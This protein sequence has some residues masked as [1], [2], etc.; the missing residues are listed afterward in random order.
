MPKRS[1]SSLDQDRL[2]RL[3][4]AQDGVVSRSQLVELGASRADVRRLVARREL[5]VV[6]PGVYVDHGARP[7]RAQRRW[8]AVLACA[9]AA[10]HRESALD[11]HG[12]TRDRRAGGTGTEPVRLVVGHD[13][14]IRPPEGVVVERVAEHEQWV[15][16]NRRPPRVAVE[17][18]LLKT[19]ADRDP[20]GAV[21]LLSDAVHQ[22]LTTAERL[23]Q[24]VGRLPRLPRRAFLGEV[25]ADVASG[26]RSVLEQRY[27]RDVERAHG[28]P[29]G[30][31]QL[32]QDTAS[33]VVHRD[34]R[35]APERV[36]V[37]LDGAFGHRD[38]V[39]RWSD[40]QRDLDASVD[41]HLTLRPGWAQVLE[42]CRLAAIVAQ[43]LR[44]RGWVGV[45]RPCG[46][47]CALGDSGATGPT[48]R[49]SAPPSATKPADRRPS[50]GI[51]SP[52]D[53]DH[54]CPL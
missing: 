1:T 20:A 18:A 5:F 42:P 31:R 8:A 49:P 43:V 53:P 26:A 24:T 33:G 25:L 7:T 41:D 15:Q 47:A 28:L 14:R 22:G 54:R 36:L 38:A 39:D 48:W 10:L 50:L 3:L 34:V 16:P 45:P 37:E 30:E 21:A 32:R 29:P 44:R 52:R 2:A 17:F 51:G 11:A 23:A 12:M 35:Y 27:L 4:R 40:L 19:A 9:P 46:P 13:R 6:H